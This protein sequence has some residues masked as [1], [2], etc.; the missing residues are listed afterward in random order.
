MAGKFEKAT[1]RAYLPRSTVDY[2]TLRA[3]HAIAE[4]RGMSWGRAAEYALMNPG[5]FEKT[6]KDLAKESPWF[7]NDVDIFKESF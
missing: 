3:I 5:E 1:S 2:V 6:L 7:Q 4:R